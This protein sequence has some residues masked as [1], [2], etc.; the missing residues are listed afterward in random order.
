MNS[1]I[2]FFFAI[3]GLLRLVGLGTGNAYGYIV[4]E[5][6]KSHSEE[7]SSTGIAAVVCKFEDC[8][9]NIYGVK[10]S[11]IGIEGECSVIG[12]SLGVCKNLAKKCEFEY[13]IR[14]SVF[15][16]SV[17]NRSKRA[18]QTKIKIDLYVPDHLDIAVDS[19]R[20]C[21]S[22]ADVESSVEASITIGDLKFEDL[23]GNVKFSTINGS[24]I[25]WDVAEIREGRVGNGSIVCKYS[26]RT[27]D[28]VDMNV[29]NGNIYISFNRLPGA[30]LE[31]KSNYG[32]VHLIN[33]PDAP[34]IQREGR[35]E[36]TIGSG[37]RHFELTTIN[38]SIIFEVESKAS[39]L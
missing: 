22:I 20:G 26:E 9:V 36:T 19:K 1:R 27:P 29:I 32:F 12:K 16:F 24:V 14:D 7:F 8:F 33:V 37:E 15:Y 39:S 10:D 30:V 17:E 4:Q 5:A 34:T 3:I 25:L 28:V 13:D 11:Q 38:G 6:V 18:Y 31:A 2:R 21:I 23:Q 35:I